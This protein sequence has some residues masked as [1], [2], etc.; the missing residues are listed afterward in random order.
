VGSDSGS[1]FLR[2]IAL[3]IDRIG[4]GLRSFALVEQRSKSLQHRLIRPISD[5]WSS[6][7]RSKSCQPDTG[8]RRFRRNSEPPFLITVW[9]CT[10]TGTATRTVTRGC[11]RAAQIRCPHCRVSS[12]CC[13]AS[14]SA[15]RMVSL[16]GA[17]SVEYISLA[18]CPGSRLRV[19][20]GSPGARSW[21]DAGTTRYARC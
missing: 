3:R 5:W 18:W 9:V 14:G 8:Q 15:W 16:P 7:R 2:A 11:V 12:R 21:D 17:W 6:R 13:R 20:I 10:A 4:D 1:L 19:V